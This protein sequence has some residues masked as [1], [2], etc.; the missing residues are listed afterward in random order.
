MK[1]RSATQALLI[2]VE[3]VKKGLLQ[4]HK[5][6]VV[7]YDFSDAFGSVNRNRLLYKLGSDFGITG[8]L[9]LHIHSF[10]SDRY[11]RLRINDMFGEWIE[12]EVGTSAGTSLGPLL[13]VLSVHE[14]FHRRKLPVLLPC[15]VSF[16]YLVDCCFGNPFIF[17]F[18]YSWCKT[19]PEHAAVQGSSQLS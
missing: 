13:F 18:F 5:V 1:D 16:L 17:F 11:A 6:G 4:G 8:K 12:S 14:V 15:P 2:L 7:F 19:F 3:Q 9:F 10:L